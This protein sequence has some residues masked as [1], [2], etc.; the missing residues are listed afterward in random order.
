[1]PKLNKKVIEGIPVPPPGKDSIAWDSELKGFG[2]RV[3][4]SGIRTFFVNYRNTRGRMRRLSIGRYGT[5]APSKARRLAKKRLGEV[6]TGADPAAEKR[7]ARGE[8]TFRELAEEYV[9]RRA[10]QKKSGHEDIRIIE[11]D[12]LKPWGH[13]AAS[14][15]KRRDVIRLADEIKDR[16]APIMANRTLALI[17]RV[18]NF[19]ISRDIVEANPTA[20]VKAPGQEKRRDRILDDKEIKTLWEKLNDLQS[21]PIGLSAIRYILVTAQRPGEVVTA[22][23]SEID[24]EGGLWTIPTEKSKN[25]LAH[26]VP[27]SPLALRI[28]RKQERL[29]RYVFASPHN[30]ER[31][32]TV[33][34]LLH[35]IT[36]N[37]DL[38]GLEHFSP[39]D[40]R[41]TAA[42][43]IASMGFSRLVIAKILNH[44]ENGVTAIYDR[45]SY[46][47]E[48]RTALNAW[49]EK[50]TDILKGASIETTS[51]LS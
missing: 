41:R 45:H 8:A 12:L 11:K 5:I 24:L 25:G 44:L 22:E 39:H 35:V 31:H 48:K 28:L 27:L 15:I 13:L 10:S 21:S 36:R 50:L 38:L 47:K 51:N 30:S 37:L 46:D 6:S 20:L 14:E 17:R 32:F 2:I 33:N 42:S 23:W 29:G 7:A 49:S 18:Y 19:G 1:M 43:H 4:P 26:R 9:Q 40:L 3:K 16:G 34:G